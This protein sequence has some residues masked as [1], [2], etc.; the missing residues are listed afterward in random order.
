MIYK[1]AA[2]DGNQMF[3]YEDKPKLNAETLIKIIMELIDE[4]VQMHKKETYFT[5]LKKKK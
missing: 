4:D 1:P 5:M 3:I 2:F